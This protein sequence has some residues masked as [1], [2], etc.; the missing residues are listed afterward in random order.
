MQFSVSAANTSTAPF[1]IGFA[2]RQGDIAAAAYV[3]TT[4]TN[5][6]VTIKN[7]WPD[8][9]VKFAVVAGRA[10]LVGGVPL[11][12][13]LSSTNA[14]PTGPALTLAELK[15]TSVTA[16][17]A[18]GSFGNVA[19]TGA[20][21][22]APFQAWIAGPE[23]SS[24][25]YRKPV[26]TDAHLVAWLEVRLYAGGSVEVLPWLENGYLKVANPVS[27]AATYA[28]TLGGSQR[29]S[30]LIDLPHHCRTPL[31]S[32]VALS[33]WLSADPGVEMHHDVAYLQS[34][35]LVPTYRAVVPSSSAI[36]AA[37]PSTF[38]P[39]AQGPFTYSG[40]SMASSGYQTAIGL[41]PQ[42]DVLYLTANSGREFGAVVRGGFSAGRYAIHYRDETTNRPLRFSSYPNLVL[43]GSGSGIKDVGGS[44]L[45]QT[46]PATGGPTFPAAWD[47]A[48][49]PSVGFM[50]YLLT[51]RWYFMEEVQFAA[52]AHYLWNSD[53]AAR[54][55]ASQGLM[56][57]VPG[58]VQIRAS[59]WV[60][61]TLA[62]ALCVTADAD[63]VIRGELKAS[64]EANVVAFNDFYATGN[65][66]PFGFLDGGSYPSG[67]C[68]VAAWQNDFCTA[69]FGYL[70][71]MNLGL[72]GT[73]S[74]KL[75]NFFAWLAQSIVGR[76]G[77]NANAP[78]AWYI[79]AAPY[80]WA[81][82]PNPTP[83]WSSASGWYTSWFEMYR[84]TYLP[85]RNGVE[86]VGVYSG[87]SF[88]S[89][90][91][92]VLN[93]EIFPGATAYWGNLQPAIAYAVR[94]GA[95]GALQAYNRMINATNYA[96]LS[97]DF[98][99]APVWGVRPA[100]A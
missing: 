50:A 21:W 5:A 43:V 91:D 72:S 53:S 82:S 13:A 84:A 60:I 33:Y 81:I 14:A 76:L 29:F 31:I 88:V 24:W 77:S 35:E 66:N 4:L 39:L 71:S 32:G 61:R 25:V 62:Q 10:P 19:W 86:A 16:A 95:G 55:N 97:S 52:T 56:L 90:T 40:D 44:T 99:S 93:S 78:N 98:N 68:R 58:A 70:K 80:T 1:C 59:G 15:A 7:R 42:H 63:S 6:Q 65:S 41:L 17:I 54:R 18:C 85:S 26:G 49:H 28:F 94:H 48:H 47:P 74:A 51:G 45:N 37:L 67:I 12:V 46:T 9:S 73:A 75:D 92:G 30:A 22:D 100:S 2:F 79:N 27:K 20:D 38:T 87:Q 8:G 69:A 36:V 57:P 34:S 23:M 83:N 64:L 96:L 11:T 89:N 3:A